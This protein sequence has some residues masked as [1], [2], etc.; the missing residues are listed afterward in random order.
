M[1]RIENSVQLIG[2]VCSIPKIILTKDSVKL[3][4]FVLTTS[5]RYKT[6]AGEQM[7]DLEW[8]FASARGR[9]AEIIEKKVVKGSTVLLEGK[10]CSRK[11]LSKTHGEVR[12]VEVQIRDLL[13]IGGCSKPDD[14]TKEPIKIFVTFVILCI[15]CVPQ[16]AS[17]THRINLLR[18]I[19][20][21]LCHANKRLYEICKRS[22]SDP[23]Y[24]Q[25]LQKVIL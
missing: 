11:F 2:K 20:V 4:S 18:V 15:L 1:T 21:S 22:R 6:S 8:H 14:F 12:R 24:P 3:A 10:L 5:E 25:I 19:P 13:V 7:N 9:L 17:D 16:T 23:G